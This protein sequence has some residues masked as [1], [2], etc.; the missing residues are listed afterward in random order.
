[1]LEVRSESPTPVIRD[2]ETLLTSAEVATLL[3]V[4]PTSVI[5][6]SKKGYLQ[7][8]RTPGGHRRIRVG[9]VLSFL[10]ARQMPVPEALR[11]FDVRQVLMVLK[12]PQELTGIRRQ[13]APAATR[14]ELNTAASGLDALVD[15][16]VTRPHVFF[17][18]Q[19]AAPD[20]F[21]MASAARRRPEL[22]Q[23]KVM[24]LVDRDDPAIA[25]KAS[26]LGISVVTRP[27]N[28][29]DLFAA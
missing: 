24:L 13:L 29:L 7:Y 8:Y 17:V 27:F 4:D 28:P 10:H 25:A 20:G 14:I 2:A 6:W 15:L 23:V 19:S 5:N 12:D 9:D 21:A 18:E 16:G 11:P 1:M 22:S 3:N 26:S